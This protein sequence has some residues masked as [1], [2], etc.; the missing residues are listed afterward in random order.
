MKFMDGDVLMARITPSLE[1]GKTSIY[2]ASPEA[3]GLPAFGST[4]FIVI[5]GREGVSDSTF[6]YYVFTS[7]E[8]REHAISSMNGSS[9]RQR[10]QHDSLAR[11]KIDLPSIE[12]QRDIAGT[13]GAL[14]DK[15]ESNRRLRALLR[16]LGRARFQQAV[17]HESH[18]KV[19]DDLTIS[20]TRGVTPKYADG[21]PL[22]PLVINQKCIRDG[23]VSLGPARQMQARDVPVTK[24]AGSGDIL[25]NSTGTGTLGRLARWHSGDIF[26]DSHVSVVKPDPSQVEPVILAYALFGRQADIE[27]FATGSTGQTELSP[28]RLGS[29]P[30]YIPGG[31]L[32]GLSVDLYAIE[33]R[34]QQLE[35]E[36]TRLEAVRDT[37]LPEL[38]S[39]RIGLPVE[40]RA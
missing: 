36:I 35:A 5:R 33:E 14:D 9:G 40:V 31:K 21:E 1:N 4:E 7:P 3:E 28:A 10:V 6:A 32:N 27:D 26:V 11:F 13:L 37:L 17:E 16:E 2:R 38:V 19:L 18:T 8:V 20:I 39:R 15:I 29:L 34:A 24:R 30:V 22:A 23:W 12:E 25:V